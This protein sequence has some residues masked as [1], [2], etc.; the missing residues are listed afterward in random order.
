[1]GLDHNERGI[2]SNVT[3]STIEFSK[4]DAKGPSARTLRKVRAGMERDGAV[5]FG[6]LF[7]MPL[8]K[9]LRA[10]VLRRHESEELRENGLVRDIGGRYAALLPFEGP[11]LEPAFYAN[12]ALLEIVAALLGTAYCI[13][14]L[15]TVI[16]LPGAGRQHQHIDGPLRFD[17]SVGGTKKMFYGDLSDLPPYAVTLCVPLCDVDE[18][19]GP[20]AI[21]PGSHRAALRA[22]PPGRTELLREFPEERMVGDFGRSFLFDYRVFHCGTPNLSRKPRPVLMF[23]FT[24][25]WY[26]DPNLAEVFPNV[27]IAKRDLRQIPDRYKNLFMLAPAARRPLW[28]NKTLGI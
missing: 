13:G 19:N 10:S 4:E 21:W 26:R 22:R 11:F 28:K 14:S 5:A 16:A 7:P 9:R 18:V 24:R 23:V 12:P 6:G 20:T 3:I 2:F 1:M 17:R 25:S 15:E 27:V 8:L